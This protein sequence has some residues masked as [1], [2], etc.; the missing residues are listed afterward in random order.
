MVAAYVVAVKRG[1]PKEQWPGLARR[2]RC[3]FV[4]AVPGLFA[5]VIIIGGTLS[6]IFTVTESAAIGAIYALLV[7]VF[8]YRS[9]TRAD[10]WTATI[11]ATKTTAMVMLLIGTA[12]AFGYVL[13]VHQVP[14]KTIALMHGITTNPYMI[15]LI[16]NVILLMLGCIMDM[17]GLILICTPI[18]LPV[19]KAIGMDPVHFGIIMMLNLGIGL[20][21]PPVGHVP[22]RRLFHRQDHDR[23]DGQDDLAVLPRDVRR[24]DVG[25]LCPGGLAVDPQRLAEMRLNRDGRRGLHFLL[26]VGRHAGRYVPKGMSGCPSCASLSFTR[27]SFMNSYP[28]RLQRAR[29]YARKITA[30]LAIGL[31]GAGAA[32][33]Q[34]PKSPVTISISDPAGDL[35]LTQAAIDEYVKTHPQLISKVNIVRAPPHPSCRA[36]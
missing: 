15:L 29:R 7:T 2:W 8:V 21:T 10:F 5:T 14:A 13:A 17:A 30:A 20:C 27:R 9:L 24:A 23:G 12:S 34:A 22:V 25:H 11:N 1:Y 3:R 28:S 16:I 19:V 4:G 32:L 6:G 35:A 26:L 31:I 36:S 33:A 18:F